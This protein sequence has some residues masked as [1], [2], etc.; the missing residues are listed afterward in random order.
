M[1]KTKRAKMV[2]QLLL[3]AK[4]NGHD[5]SKP[6]PLR[7]A[8]EFLKDL[9]KKVQGKIKP[10]AFDQTVNLSVCL[11]LDPA[12]TDQA[13]RAVVSLPHGTGKT[14][15]IAV[16]TNSEERIKEAQAHGAVLAGEEFI[17]DLGQGINFD[18]L[19]TTP[20]MM[21]VLGKFSR[22]L[23][24]RGLMP[25]PKTGTV[26]N[27]IATA[28]KN[29]KAGQVTFKNNKGVKSGGKASTAKKGDKRAAKTSPVD[30][31]VGKA[32][33]S[34]EQLEDNIKAVFAALVKVKP[35]SAK[36]QYIQRAYLSTTMSPG[37]CI[38]ISS[39]ANG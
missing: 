16:F 28:M 22:I 5:L 31:G 3:E 34:V 7:Y 18:V 30:L 9:P 27:D 20:D 21:G 1:K 19:V 14:V 25:N 6:T 35:Q 23:G 32:S 12:K 37:V 36:G 33:F 39:L 24:P 11:G 38:D 10:I 13:V 15:R 29:L 17:N 26:T 2:D 8:L 4:E